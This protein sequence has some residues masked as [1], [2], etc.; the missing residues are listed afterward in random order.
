MYI[1]AD[2]F[3]LVNLIMNC[4][5]LVLTA[6]ASGLRYRGWRIL[7]AAALGSVYALGDLAGSYEY[8]YSPLCKAAA[9]VAIV[10]A[11]FGA[12][13]AY[14]LAVSVACFFAVSFLLGGAVFG[15]LFLFQPEG[16]FY[17]GDLSSLRLSWDHLVISVGFTVLLVLVSLRRLTAY[18]TKREMFFP[19]VIFYRGRQAAM[20]SLLDT[21]NRLFSTLGRK[22]VVLVAQE[23]LEPLLGD[24]AA[25]FLRE[26]GPGAWL[27]NLERCGDQ[28]WISRIEIIPYQAVGSNSLLLGFRPDWVLVRTR[29]GDIIS[30]DV[31][32][33]IYGGRMAFDDSYHALLHPVVLKNHRSREGAVVCA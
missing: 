14:I 30:S 10:L 31:V 21:G 25:R 11:A 19:L 24:Q 32:I 2:L 23:A 1:Y 8:L 9:S 26:T 29:T 6:K 17:S 12:T 4:I 3:F 22:P 7:A 18:F 5:I 16:L 27:D 15:W 33:G 28:A 20:T 13:S